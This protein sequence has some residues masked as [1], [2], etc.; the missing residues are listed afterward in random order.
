MI[1]TPKYS[2]WNSKKNAEC[3]KNNLK[4]LWWNGK[5]LLTQVYLHF[6][7]LK[8]KEVIPVK[9]KAGKVAAVFNEDSEVRTDSKLT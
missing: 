1:E 9:P 3:N 4:A 8:T 6:Q 7:P 5:W 2:V